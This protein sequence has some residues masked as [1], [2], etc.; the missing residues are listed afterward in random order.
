MAN[1]YGMWLNI[2]NIFV[3]FILFFLFSINNIIFLFNRDFQQIEVPAEFV[4]SEDTKRLWD[5]SEAWT[6]LKAPKE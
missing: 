1:L 6:S 4:K 3:L 2:K 5:I